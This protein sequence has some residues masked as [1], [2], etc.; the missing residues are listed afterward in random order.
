MKKS[1]LTLGLLLI[2]VS[3]LRADMSCGD[4]GTSCGQDEHCCEH[5][6]AMFSGDHSA[7]PAYVQGQCAPK[8][9]KCASF[10][11]GNKDCKTGFFGS[12]SV[13]CVNQPEAGSTP[14][15]TCAYSELSCPGNGEQL[16]IRSS[17][18]TR[19]LQRG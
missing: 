15:Y 13:C 2:S 5:V 7:G 11:C 10:W 8:G 14:Q 12:P 6:M 4:D 9:Q 19:T 18:P 1:F 3:F 17:T 16:T